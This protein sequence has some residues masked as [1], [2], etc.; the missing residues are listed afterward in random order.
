MEEALDYQEQKGKQ[1][2]KEIEL[3]KF[4]EERG[5]INCD[6]YSCETTNQ[7]REEVKQ[8]Q[9]KFIKQIDKEKEQEKIDCD[10]CGKKVSYKNWNDEQD[11]CRKCARDLEDYL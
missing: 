9:E 6:C 5:K 10:N 11:C 3:V 2:E 8:E 4:H 1:Y 7:V